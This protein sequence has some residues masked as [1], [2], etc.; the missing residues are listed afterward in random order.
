MERFLSAVQWISDNRVWI[1]PIV[2]LISCGALIRVLYPV[3]REIVEK[4]E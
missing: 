4:M 2:L 1:M 3:F